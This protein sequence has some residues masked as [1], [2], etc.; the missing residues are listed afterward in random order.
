[1]FIFLCDDLSINLFS[2]ARPVWLVLGLD[3]KANL[4][5]IQLVDSGRELPI[6]RV[7]IMLAEC[8]FRQHH[9]A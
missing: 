4:T 5:L 2:A 7:T 1:L 8:A 9:K 6:V 3:R